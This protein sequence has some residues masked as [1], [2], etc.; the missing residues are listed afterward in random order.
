MIGRFSTTPVC[1]DA[2]VGL[3]WA[4]QAPITQFAVIA[5][6]AAWPLFL[7]WFGLLSLP[8]A[9]KGSTSKKGDHAMRIDLEDEGTRELIAAIVKQAILDHRTGYCHPARHPDARTFLIE[10]GMLDPEDDSI[11]CGHIRV[12]SDIVPRLSS[13]AWSPMTPHQRQKAEEA[14][15]SSALAL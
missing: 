1:N 5:L 13:D 4:V 12:A 2:R 6:S 14:G 8:N 11:R 10:A 9:C 3:G 15:A 7:G